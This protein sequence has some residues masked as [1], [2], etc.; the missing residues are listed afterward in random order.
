MQQNMLY[1]PNLSF[2]CQLLSHILK[3]DNNLKMEMYGIHVL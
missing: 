2:R 1:Y 3:E